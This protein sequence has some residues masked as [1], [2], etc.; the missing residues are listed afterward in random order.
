M[1]IAQSAVGILLT[2]NFNRILAPNKHLFTAQ[3]HGIPI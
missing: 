3:F 2:A 1:S